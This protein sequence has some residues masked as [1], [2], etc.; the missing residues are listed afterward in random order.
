MILRTIKDLPIRAKLLLAF[1]IVGV[2]PFV[3]YFP[4]ELSSNWLR[5][6]FGIDAHIFT[7]GI[8][9]ILSLVMALLFARLITRP[10]RLLDETA[11]EILFGTDKPAFGGQVDTNDEIGQLARTFDLL[12]TKQKRRM[13]E[14]EESEKRLRYLV[15]KMGEG[16]IVADRDETIT[17]VN[18]KM[19]EILGC[20][21]DE[22]IGRTIYEFLDET[23]KAI[24]R[25]KTM[26][27]MKGLS[28][29]YELQFIPKSG[30]LVST[31]V[32]A[33]PLYSDDDSYVGSFAVVM[34]VTES[35]KLEKRQRELELELLQNHK[36]S[37]IGQ[38][39]AGIV[40]NLNNPLTTVQLAAEVMREK[41]QTKEI[42]VILSEC[43]RMKE[44]VSNVLRKGRQ[45]TE[46]EKRLFDL[47]E[48]V[49]TEL[50]FLEADPRFKHRIE[51]EYNFCDSPVLIEGIYSD[52][53]QSFNNIV[54]NAIDAM[55][56]SQAKKLT[57]ATQMD[58]SWI[59]I[60]VKDTGC[61]IP[62]E[63]IPKLFDPFFTSKPRL[64]EQKGDEPTGTGLGLSSMHQLLSPYGAKFQIRSEVGK[65]TEFVI[66]LPRTL[67]SGASDQ[68]SIM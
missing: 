27:R 7:L 2:L 18:D 14:Q 30:D 23:N 6:T 17:F 66:K 39:T 20:E 21:S 16:L 26:N 48:M 35:K 28:E 61:G 51:K 32:S 50:G 42:E 57:V 52:F 60:I 64:G 9:I 29:K 19:C 59:Y 45:E 46:T 33:A 34:D 5:P 37:A 11:R 31:I 12:L 56:A 53:S 55:H 15:E 38:L 43:N 41:S 49:R 63:N 36:L 65:G 67:Q 22:L 1:L 4:L 68:P 54:R 47:N 44:I 25:E 24:L 10:L 62:K 3:L 40:H 13:R 8:R 58:E